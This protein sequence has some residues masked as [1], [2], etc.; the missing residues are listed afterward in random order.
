MD[1]SK[2]TQVC[3]TRLHELF[4]PNYDNELRGS[5]VTCI[6]TMYYYMALC[7]MPFLFL[8]SNRC[9]DLLQILFKS[10]VLPLFFMELWIILCNF[11]P[12]LIKPL[13]RNN[14]YLEWR[15][16]RGVVSCLFKFGRCDLYLRFW[17]TIFVRHIFD[18]FS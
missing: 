8:L 3:S 6:F 13:T 14:S 12:I 10:G 1:L 11:W 16:P 4:S 15:V 2:V 7:N 9:T 5:Y 18:F 17:F